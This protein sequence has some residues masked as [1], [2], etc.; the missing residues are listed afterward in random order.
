[1]NKTEFKEVVSGLPLARPLARAEFYESIGSTNDVVAAWAA[2]G[3]AGVCL[4]AA[5][6]QTQGRGRDGRSW[7]TPPGSALAFSLLLPP[8]AGFQAS[9]LGRVSGLGA[10]A[11]SEA[12]GGLGIKAEIKWPNDVL[13]DGKKLCGVLPEAHW[14][15][16]QLQAVI[17]GIGINVAA[18]S[19]PDASQLRFPATSVE[20]AAGR[21]VAAA[22]LLRAVLESLLTWLPRMPQAEFLQAWEQRLAYRN[23][24]VQLHSG[25]EPVT[26]IL[27][28]LAAD[29]SLRLVVDGAE[30]TY[31]AG[32]V[33]L[34][35][36]VDRPGN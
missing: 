29:G 25:P 14:A 18:E 10:L 9:Q 31:P 32:Q 30:R 13:A 1:M 19:V 22:G 17:L 36:L 2:E 20:Q 26:G 35:P 7:H 3:A 23:Q 15:G 8:P 5:D 11:V 28:G 21:P 4:A 33:Q 16:S 6:E 34:R 24:P 27:A 12:L